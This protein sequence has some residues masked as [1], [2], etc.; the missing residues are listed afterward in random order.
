MNESQ[1]RTADG[2]FG[3]VPQA[4]SE[5]DLEGSTAP[6][7]PS[8]SVRLHGNH[9]PLVVRAADAEAAKA[10]GLERLQVPEEDRGKVTG[11][12]T[13]FPMRDPGLTKPLRPRPM[14]EAPG[15]DGPLKIWR[16]VFP[17]Q[18]GREDHTIKA[19]NAHLA[20]QTAFDLAQIDE[21]RRT[22]MEQHVSVGEVIPVRPDDAAR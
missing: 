22:W 11:Q 2:R 14:P 18:H 16:V 4:E 3:P 15:G 20:I 5:I 6:E 1:P 10:A 9:M 17:G 8:W 19:A 21:P 12:M 7:L 13:V